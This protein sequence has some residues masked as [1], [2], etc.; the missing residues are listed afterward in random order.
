VL[1]GALEGRNGAEGSGGSLILGHG[2][3]R[4]GIGRDGSKILEDKLENLLDIE[5]TGGG[6]LELARK[7]LGHDRS[8]GIVE[9]HGVDSFSVNRKESDEDRRRR[10]CKSSV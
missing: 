2:E 3:L 7:Q 9:R 10:K 5:V 6:N 1:T 4:V 8:L